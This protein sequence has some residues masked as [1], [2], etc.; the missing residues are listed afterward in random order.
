MERVAA[1]FRAVVMEVIAACRD[2]R[3]SLAPADFPLAQLDEKRLQGVLARLE[4]KNQ[5]TNDL[6]LQLEQVK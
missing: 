5:P 3:Q 2:Q 1:R 6:G 4:R